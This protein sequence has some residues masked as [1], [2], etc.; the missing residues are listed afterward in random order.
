MIAVFI[1]LKKD[2]F[3]ELKSFSLGTEIDLFK[4]F[5]CVIPICFQYYSLS[6]IFSVAYWVSFRENIK[7]G[8]ERAFAFVVMTFT[9]LGSFMVF[10]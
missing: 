4:G 6:G 10:F 9:F 1:C 7:I 8:R 2:F 3:Y 5:D